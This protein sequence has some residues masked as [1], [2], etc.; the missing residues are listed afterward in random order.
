MNEPGVP[1]LVQNLLLRSK[2]DCVILADALH[3]IDEFVC[4]LMD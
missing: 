2:S 3:A 4:R 1:V